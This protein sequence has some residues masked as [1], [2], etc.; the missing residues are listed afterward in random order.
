MATPDAP[1]EAN[2]A[3]AAPPPRTLNAKR[4]L[5]MAQ[6]VAPANSGNW[7]PPMADEVGD[8]FPGYQLRD[9]LGAG[10]MGAVYR[11]W[12][13]K[14]ERWV[15]IKILP[16]SHAFDDEILDRFQREARTLARLQHRNVVAI[17]DFGA[18]DVGLT[19]FVMELVQ[20]TDLAQELR[21]RGPLQ[22]DRAATIFG[23][24]CDAVAAAHA[25][26]I[27]HRDLKPGNVLLDTEGW[28]K[29][30][31]FGL[32]KAVAQSEHTVGASTL[33]AG[34]PVYMAPE[35]ELG[36]ATERSDIYSLGVML[37]EILTGEKP[38]GSFPH[39][40]EVR[41]LDPRLDEVVAQA[42]RRNPQ[43]R[44]ESV[45]E[46]KAAFF[47]AAGG[48]V[49]LS[50]AEGAR[51]T[52]LLFAE[53]AEPST[54]DLTISVGE[55]QQALSRAV[56]LFQQCLPGSGGR[57]LEMSG[58][59]LHAE[60]PTPSEAVRA[61]L[62]F[63]YL[64]HA[65][66]RSPVRV[67][68][69]S[70]EV[71][72]QKDP[73]T[74]REKPF[75]PAVD[76]AARI[77]LLA[78]PCQILMT[79][80]VFGEARQFL[81]EHPAPPDEGMTMGVPLPRLA[82]LFHGRYR[83]HNDLATQE[84]PA[85]ICEVGAEGL[86]SLQ[87]PRD[88]VY[89]ARHLDADEADTLGWRPS[90]AQEIPSR[91][92][93]VLEKRMGEGGFGE[94]WLAR[95]I[96]TREERVFKFC[97]DADRLRSFRREEKLFVLLKN[98][99]GERED[100][101]PIYETQQA[102][103]PYFIESRYYPEGNL[104]QWAERKGGLT[105]MPLSLR[106]NLLAETARTVG[107][108]HAVGVIHKDLKPSNILIRLDSQGQP[109]PVLSDFGIGALTDVSVLEKISLTESG[110]SKTLFEPDEAARA[111]TRLYAAPEYLT[112]RP[113]S[114]LGDVYALGVMLYQMVV[115]NPLAALAPGWED[116]IADK[117]LAADIAAAVH[118]KLEQRLQS[119]EALAE[120][121][122]T[123]ETRRQERTRA[124]EEKL[125]KQEEERLAQQAADLH[126]RLLRTRKLVAWFALI[127]LVALGAAWF[128]WVKQQ[129]AWKATRDAEDQLYYM[130]FDLRR[131]LQPLGQL[132]LLDSVNQRVLK[133]FERVPPSKNDVQARRAYAAALNLAG[134]ILAQQAG[135]DAAVERYLQSLST[136]EPLAAS[137]AQ[138]L[139]VQSDLAGAYDRLG[140]YH[141]DL[142]DTSEALD[143]F[144]KALAIRKKCLDLAPPGDQN[145]WKRDLSHSHVKLGGAYEAGQDRY[146]ALEEYARAQQIRDSIQ[147]DPRVIQDI[148][149]LHRLIGAVYEGLAGEEGQGDGPLMSAVQSYQRSVYYFS[150]LS[151]EQP[152]DQ[153]LK[154][155][156][157][158]AMHDLGRVFLL[159]ENLLGAQSQ[160]AEALR[161]R[162][163][164]VSHDPSNR[165]WQH[166]LALSC[167]G[168]AQLRT[169]QGRFEEADD[170]YSRCLTTL[171]RLVDASASNVEWRAHATEFLLEAGHIKEQ[172]QQWDAAQEFF[173]RIFILTRR[174]EDPGRSLTDWSRRNAEAQLALAGM[175]E[176]RGQLA[177]AVKHWEAAVEILKTRLLSVSGQEGDVIRTMLDKATAALTA[178][179]A[180]T[181]GKP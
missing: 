56:A 151:Q 127:S 161:I 58:R 5:Q 55:M 117:L 123:L 164:L 162:E 68:L 83:F 144:G 136:L 25:A 11:A 110:F 36:E 85:E 52:T 167:A 62:R 148:A 15:A 46:L 178:A 34:T 39:V 13:R 70:G 87:A 105:A 65:E 112:G 173:E 158:A 29:V 97:F 78:A 104:L 59:R 84:D 174:P 121:L 98:E 100:I 102:E 90:V 7:Q 22:L 51:T 75:G 64:L 81:R 72:S 180:A 82:F 95:H 171:S 147:D 38:V 49:S 175:F 28:V 168:I 152:F 14:L 91:A 54:K 86:A 19:Y 108:A 133:H 129:E 42:L 172:L 31:D 12:D 43:D 26:G 142:G 179:K 139:D 74:G 166:D 124:A 156:S 33:G 63:Q 17:H 16:P 118:G 40:S 66:G 114:I 107:V 71:R 24:V 111:G 67:G 176:K 3:G 35:Q 45:V 77:M 93:W 157:A 37:Y 88:T 60:F 61:A 48:P 143:Y 53:L 113:P 154:R 73:A 32:A 153:D 150:N 119:A 2:R 149:S 44:F 9:L 132:E 169:R 155:E 141:R 115:A 140:D 130:T 138:A 146:R 106:L 6:T 163:Q 23:Q 10:G 120:R 79:R 131:R 41:P 18:T 96:R 177:A 76:L 159:Q 80:A 27:I 69:H 50:G 181:G 145:D 89:A 21:S 20:G 99:L 1:N 8:Q 128:G 126:I 170:Y 134:D 125:R 94:V 101:V 116:D 165:E 109:H 92:G 160:L 122:E 30:A 103:R 4:L 137:N 135:P 47:R 57:L